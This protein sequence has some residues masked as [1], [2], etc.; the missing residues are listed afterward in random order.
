MIIREE[1]KDPP[2]MQKYEGLFFGDPEKN[3]L[4]F[5]GKGFSKYLFIR[6]NYLYV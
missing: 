1:V 6:I 3:L 4:L 2:Y 5:W